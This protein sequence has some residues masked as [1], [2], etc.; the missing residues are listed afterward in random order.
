MDLIFWGAIIGVIVLV[1]TLKLSIYPRQAMKW[2]ID[3]FEKRGYK[4]KALPFSLLTPPITQILKGTK[5]DSLSY[6]KEKKTFQTMMLLFSTI[7]PMLL[8]TYVIVSLLSNWFRLRA[9]GTSSRVRA[10]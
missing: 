3:Q 1:L 10:S 6:V 9:K 2:Q 8:L 5:D 7:V 4:V